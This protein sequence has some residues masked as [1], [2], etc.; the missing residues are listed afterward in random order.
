MDLNHRPLPYQGSALTELSYRPIPSEIE[1]PGDSTRVATPRKRVKRS[2][3]VPVTLGQGDLDTTND[4]ADQ[5]VQERDEHRQG[6]PH[7]GEQAPGE[8]QPGEDPRSV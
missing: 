5:V 1:Q 7:E 4:V 2:P 8:E 6:R 3:S